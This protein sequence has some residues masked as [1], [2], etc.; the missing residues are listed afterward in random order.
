LN[1]LEDKANM[2]SQQLT[3]VQFGLVNLNAPS[4]A[5]DAPMTYRDSSH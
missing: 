2:T 1:Q 4:S 5:V 3:E